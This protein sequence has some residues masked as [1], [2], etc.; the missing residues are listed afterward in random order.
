MVGVPSV[1]GLLLSQPSE[2]VA[3]LLLSL[4]AF[5]SIGE[6]RRLREGSEDMYPGGRWGDPA[7][8]MS[9]GDAAGGPGLGVFSTWLDVPPLDWLLGGWWF[10]RPQPWWLK[11]VELCIGRTAMLAALLLCLGAAPEAQPLDEAH[12]PCRP[13][14]IWGDAVCR[15]LLGD[16]TR[17]GEPCNRDS[18]APE[19]DSP[20]DEADKAPTV[21]PGMMR[22]PAMGL[23]TRVEA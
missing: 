7:G 9:E 6:T 21:Q 11:E 12:K 8:L 16:P 2:V 18:A 15:A 4:L 17:Y 3:P 10:S 13:S 23:R 20:P 1:L 5:I 22:A 14:C 19:H